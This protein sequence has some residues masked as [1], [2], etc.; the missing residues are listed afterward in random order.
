MAKRVLVLSRQCL[1][2]KGIETLLSEHAEIEI[3]K[4]DDITAA[5]ECIQNRR[6]DVVIVNCDDPDTDF[7]PAVLCILRER[8]GISVIGLSL[9]DNQIFVYRGEQKEIHHV[10]DLLN[11][12]QD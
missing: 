3:L 7:T 5:V 1:F 6:P 10:D 2:S 4:Q 11:A 8:L 9:K 12:I